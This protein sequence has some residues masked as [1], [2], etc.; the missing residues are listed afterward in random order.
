MV[1]GLLSTLRCRW[2]DLRW[3]GRRYLVWVWWWWFVTLQCLWFL[4]LGL[5]LWRRCVFRVAK[6]CCTLVGW[7]SGCCIWVG[8]YRLVSSWVH[9]CAWL[10][11]FAPWLG[12]TMRSQSVLVFTFQRCWC[13][14]FRLR[15]CQILFWMQ[16]LLLISIRTVSRCFHSHFSWCP[17]WL[18]LTWVN[19]KL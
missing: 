4:I 2:L 3:L 15:F 14:G 16:L 7:I 6:R 13:L 11:S 10:R 8:I 12:L 18:Q 17:R 1:L 19:K 5:I 9:C